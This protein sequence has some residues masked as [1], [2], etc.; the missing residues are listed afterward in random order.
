ME[1][2]E[3]KEV[4]TLDGAKPE[5]KDATAKGVDNLRF[6][7]SRENITRLGELLDSVVN[8]NKFGITN[9]EKAYE[10]LVGMIQKIVKAEEIK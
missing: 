2:Q 10:A 3:E 5:V 8:A 6:V 4:E 1:E 9:Y 7:I